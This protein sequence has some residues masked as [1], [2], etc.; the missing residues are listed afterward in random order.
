MTDS[1]CPISRSPKSSR[2]CAKRIDISTPRG[3]MNAPCGPTLSGLTATK[4]PFRPRRGR[5]ADAEC[6]TKYDA[7][8]LALA[9]ALQIT[10]KNPGRRRW[11]Q[12][13]RRRP[14]RASSATFVTLCSF[15]RSFRPVA[16]TF[17]IGGRMMGGKTIKPAHP[18]THRRRWLPS[19]HFPQ[20]KQTTDYTD[21]TDSESCRNSPPCSLL[22]SVVKVQ[23]LARDWSSVP[24][25]EI[26]GLNCGF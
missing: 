17:Q 21:C 23:E 22:T 9:S 2:S 7:S 18:F 1:R 10:A 16:W 19:S 25:C 8:G 3:V 20:F 6:Q 14:L 5:K 4:S 24:I 26:C 15:F 13:G 12:A 11:N